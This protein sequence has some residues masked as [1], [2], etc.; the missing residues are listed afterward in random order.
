MI[1]SMKRRTLFGI[2]MVGACLACTSLAETRSERYLPDVAFLLG[3]SGRGPV[4]TYG[5]FW[6]NEKRAQ[7]LFERKAFDLAK[8]LG[9]ATSTSDAKDAWMP[10]ILELL[11]SYSVDANEVFY[12]ADRNIGGLHRIVDF[13]KNNPAAADISEV[14]GRTEKEIAA[15]KAKWQRD[16]KKDRT[17]EAKSLPSVAEDRSD[18]NVE[19]WRAFVV[20]NYCR[21]GRTRRVEGVLPDKTEYVR[22]EH[23]IWA[24][25][26]DRAEYLGSLVQT[27]EPGTGY[28][29]TYTVGIAPGGYSITLPDGPFWDGIVSEAS[30]LLEGPNR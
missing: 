23:E 9:F 11:E 4:G 7:A 17:G 22:S 16:A 8:K 30:K 10:K 27:L 29:V 25:S 24:G 14:L 1:R 21:N 28:E 15:I 19:C 6:P 13:E 20:G 2:L 18:G 12:F 3:M 26:A 5:G